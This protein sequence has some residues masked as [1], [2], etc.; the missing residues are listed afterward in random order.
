VTYALRVLPS[1]PYDP[2]HVGDIVTVGRNATKDDA[3]R[4]RRRMASALHFEV[5]RL[6][7][8]GEVVT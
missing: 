8:H 5:V 4:V 2:S 6:D 7:E 3:E 1:W